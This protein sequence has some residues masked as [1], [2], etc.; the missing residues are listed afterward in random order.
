MKKVASFTSKSNEKI[1]LNT[2]T[3]LNDEIKLDLIASAIAQIETKS[4]HGKRNNIVTTID[5]GHAIGLT[6]CVPT[7][8][9]DDVYY[10]VRD[11]KPWPTRCVKNRFPE[12]SSKITVIISR[13]K[14]TRELNLRAV[15]LGEQAPPETWDEA[16]IKRRYG[17][18][19]LEKGKQKAIDFWSKHALI[20]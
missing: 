17:K 4:S 7:T 18:R 8:D 3:Y 13:D 9:G 19:N 11:G 20:L 10:K 1:F 5:F 15:Y 12:A 2:T 6:R 14:E 16:A